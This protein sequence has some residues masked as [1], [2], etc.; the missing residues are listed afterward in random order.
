MLMD[1]NISVHG[2]SV[3][4]FFEIF[5]GRFVAGDGGRKAHH[6][7]GMGIEDTGGD[8]VGFGQPLC[9]PHPIE[10][11]RLRKTARGSSYTLQPIH[12]RD[13][14]RRLSMTA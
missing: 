2:L 10:N 9:Q 8:Q 6:I 13:R 5:L 12:G 14:R 1:G 4:R 3:K 11:F 7:A